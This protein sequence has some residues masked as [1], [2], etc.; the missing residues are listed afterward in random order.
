M[1]M[2]LMIAGL[3]AVTG[4]ATAAYAEEDEAKAPKG[5]IY[6][7]QTCPVSGEKLGS[8]GEPVIKKYDGREVRFCCAGCVGKFEQDQD[9]YWK[10][11]DAAM[12]KQQKALYPMKTCVVSGQELGAMGEPV[13][14]VYKNRLVR[15]CCAGCPATF[16]KDPAKY[17]K[18]I[19]AAVIEKQKE[20]YPL[21]TCVV[22][23]QK[24]GAMGEPV[25][26]VAGNRLVRFCCKGCV[27]QFEK[28]PQKYLDK[29]E[30]EQESPTEES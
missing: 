2:M 15:F 16:E 28:D 3:A 4:L 12:V 19:D 11:I 23:G 5:D 9:G 29:L 1:S 30:K 22:S 27:K 25:E 17:L 10:K 8:R 21:E 26:Y 7:L 24:L 14:K 18:K 20:D 13:D 6:T